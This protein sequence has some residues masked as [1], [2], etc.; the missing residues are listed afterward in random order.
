ML[1][2]QQTITAGA[3]GAIF[4]VYGALLAY[5]TVYRNAIPADILGRLRVSGGVFVTYS[6]FYGF[7]QSGIDNAAH[8]GGLV[9]G[10]A[11]G[12]IVARPLVPQLRHLGNG[13]RALFAALL[14]TATLPTAALLTP[15]TAR[16]YRQAIA[17]QEGVEAFGAEETR[18]SANFQS[19][20][21]QTRSGKISDAV[22]VG[23]LRSRI[24]PA[25][26]DALA[27]LAR[28]ELDT[29]APARKDYDL[30]MRYAVAR[31]D[32]I[33]AV[34]DYL[35]TSNPAQARIV[36]ALRTQADEALKLY[37]QRQKK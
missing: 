12:L 21:D 8:L 26:D 9:G 6:L 27:R 1:W 29:N 33:K 34:A 3:S 14:A 10:Y 25:W 13:R 24:L 11:M 4:G 17:L 35:E 18:L 23:E 2:N 16:V 19:V 15:D 32:M 7:A 28:I 31:R 37:Q 20:V 5:L 36:A 30:L 22:A